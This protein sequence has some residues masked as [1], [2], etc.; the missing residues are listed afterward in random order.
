MSQ[1]WCLDAN[2]HD[3]T[4]RGRMIPDVEPISVTETTFLVHNF[5]EVE[6]TTERAL[7][8]GSWD[9]FAPDVQVASRHALEPTFAYGK[10]GFRCVKPVNP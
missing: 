8:G 9:N 2:A 4:S 1:A 7:R 10:L 5:T 6:R 3:V